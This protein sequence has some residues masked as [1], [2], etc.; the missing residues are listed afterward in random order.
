MVRGQVM[1]GDHSVRLGISA[2]GGGGDRLY[3]AHLGGL[4]FGFLYLEGSGRLIPD[5]RSQYD[6]WQRN[7]LR[8][9]FEVYY[10]QRHREDDE[11]SRQVWKN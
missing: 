1:G 3:R 9:K 10:N 5:L 2:F 7:R 8:R 4:L 6:K 11:K